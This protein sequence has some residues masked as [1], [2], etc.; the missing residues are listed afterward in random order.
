M[1]NK[2]NKVKR[3]LRVVKKTSHAIKRLIEFQGL[4]FTRIRALEALPSEKRREEIIENEKELIKSMDI[5]SL[6][7]E[8]EE[9]EKKYKSALDTLSPE[10]RAMVT[11]CYFCGMPYWKIAMEYGFS[12][13]GA[14]K[15]LDKIV[16]KIAKAI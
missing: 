7:L 9:L 8:S 14:R 10:D 11:D 2:I 3:E 15:H 6:V 5:D 4:H 16:E 12:E 13:S 1:K